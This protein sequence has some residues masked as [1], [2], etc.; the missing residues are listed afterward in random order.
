MS[1]KFITEILKGRQK[2]KMSIM[3]EREEG[4][5]F[6]GKYWGRNYKENEENK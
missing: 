2:E 3:F 4:N 1:E 5:R 6:E